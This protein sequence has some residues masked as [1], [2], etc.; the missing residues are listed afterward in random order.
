MLPLDGVKQIQVSLN[1]ISFSEKVEISLVRN[2][3]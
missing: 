3:V 2:A 1:G